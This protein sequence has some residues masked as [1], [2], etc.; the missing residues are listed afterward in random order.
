MSLPRKFPV[1]K[2]TVHPAILPSGHFPR[3]T[4][5]SAKQPEK[6]DKLILWVCSTI[7]S[8]FPKMLTDWPSAPN[9]GT[10]EKLQTEEKQSTY[11]YRRENLED[12]TRKSYPWDE[13]YNLKKNTNP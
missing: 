5:T 2:D 11:V 6:E 12:A 1:L 7:S 8:Y 9:K 13:Y 3:M 4:L 10:E